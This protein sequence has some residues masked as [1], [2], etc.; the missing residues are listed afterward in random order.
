MKNNIK[1]GIM[2]CLTALAI[3]GVSCSSKTP[4]LVG[5]PNVTSTPVCQT[6]QVGEGLIMNRTQVIQMCKDTG[7]EMVKL[8]GYIPYTTLGDCLSLLGKQIN[9]VCIGWQ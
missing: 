1:I 8:T 9:I 7:E 5:G 6:Y 4:T 3:V 2:L